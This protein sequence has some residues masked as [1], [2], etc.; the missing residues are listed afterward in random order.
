MAIMGAMAFVSIEE[1]P[2]FKAVSDNDLSAVQTLAFTVPDINSTRSFSGDSLLSKAV[3]HANRE[4]IKVLM[5]AGADVNVRN[6]DGRTALMALSDG[7]TAE[8]TS[9]LIDA[10]AK[11][12]ARDNYGDSALIIAAGAASPSV[13]KELLKAG[14]RVDAINSAEET[15]LFAAARE[16]K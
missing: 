13:L 11:I 14:A 5:L 15:A 6:G 4:M 10:G 1:D 7:A 3:G 8:I 2:L 16:D 9:D 12:N